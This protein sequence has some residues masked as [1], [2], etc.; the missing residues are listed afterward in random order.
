MRAI[1]ETRKRISYILKLTVI[2]N[3]VAGTLISA[4]A[5]RSAFMGG[6]TVFMYFTIQSNILIAAIC[7]WGLFLL[8]RDRAVSVTWYTMKLVGTVS[9]T[10]TGVV[11]AFLLAPVLGAEAWNLQNTLT[12]AVV[13]IVSVADYFVVVSSVL[14]PELGKSRRSI[15]IYRG[16]SVYG[17]RLVDTS[18]TCLP[19]CGRIL[20]YVPGRQDRKTM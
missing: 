14:F 3:A 20:L 2:V 8:S 13:P 9:I 6:K 7:A 5:G 12:H 19:D 17:H 16:A 18:V 10:L 15:W 11:F 4:F 1:S